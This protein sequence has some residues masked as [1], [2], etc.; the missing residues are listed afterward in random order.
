[1]GIPFIDL[2]A[3]FRAIEPD[4]R[5]RIE[6]V[7]A[8]GQYIMG[9]E[10]K[11]LEAELAGYVGVSQAVACASGTDALLWPLMAWGIGP[12]DAVLTTPFT[13][14]ATAEVIAF[15]GATPVFVDIDPATFNIDPERLALALAALE[16]RDPDLHPLP[17]NF[18]ELTAKAVIPVDLFGLPADYDRLLPLCAERGLKV[19]E[20]AA[21]SFGASLHGKRT[22][23]FGDVGATSFFPAKPLGAYGDA[24]AVFTDDEALAKV[25][26]SIRIHGMGDNQYDNVRLGVTGRMDTLQAAV[27]LA[28][29]AVFPAE[30][31]ARQAIAE[32]YDAGLEGLVVTPRVPKGMASAWAQYSVL[33]EKR[34]AV[35]AAL[36]KEGVPTAVYYPKVLHQQPVFRHLGYRAGDFPVSEAASRSIFSLPMHPYLDQATQ[37]RI[38][39]TVA[40]AVA[41]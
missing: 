41:E 15:L 5:R 17:E 1:M 28:K 34:D 25:L 20:D 13:F 24:G 35:R 21:Q 23:G 10:I 12:G 40:R 27:L 16:T 14:F 7:L 8:H 22:G 2:K 36:S 18:R 26:R 29:L 31:A 4:V 38:I 3:Q 33:S 6:A 11:E 32:R 39:K 9:P 37:A 30:L 19:V